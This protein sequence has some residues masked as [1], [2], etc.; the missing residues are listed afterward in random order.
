MHQR[1]QGSSLQRHERDATKRIED[2]Y[3]ALS[4]LDD[5]GICP[6]QAAD[7]L[8]DPIL[9][10]GGLEGS[11]PTARRIAS[12]AAPASDRRRGRID[13]VVYAD[14]QCVARITVER[15]RLRQSDKG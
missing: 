11:I 8:F 12:F 1:V 4:L 7:S 10:E 15:Q 6:L 9:S 14:Q 5:E 3:D 13:E 2:A